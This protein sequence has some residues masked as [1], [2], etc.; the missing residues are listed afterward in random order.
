[1]RRLCVAALVAS[2]ALCGAGSWS[3]GAAAYDGSGVS[4]LRYG[5]AD[6]YETSLLVAEAF[7]ADA[8]G[9]LPSLVLA[10]GERWTDAV[11]AVPVAGSLG[12]PVL[13]TPPDELRGDAVEFLQRAGVTEV[14][15]IGDA[16]GDDDHG[17]SLGVS[18]EVADAVE[19]LGI[20]V[21]RVAGSDPYTTSVAAARHVIPG[22][23]GS[24]GRTAIVASGT[25]STGALVAGPFA[26]RGVHPVLLSPPE[27]LHPDVAAYLADAEIKHVVVMGGTPA[28]SAEVESAIAATGASVTRMAGRT[29][30]G[31]AAETASLIAGAYSDA[32]GR[33]CLA[34]D[35]VGVARAGVPFDAISAAPLL[36][37]QCASLVLADPERI[38]A[39]AAEVL[40][41]A[42]DAGHTFTLQVF[43][44]DAA[45]APRAIDTYLAGEDPM[46]QCRPRG[47]SADT[48]EFPQPHVF[49]PS[50]GT[51][52]VAVLFMDFHDAE[53]E[54]STR[55]EAD[56][57]LQFMEEYIETVSY[58]QLDVEVKA[59]HKWLRAPEP[60][61]HY[62]RTTHFG[63]R[64]GWL[65]SRQAVE[66]ADPVFDFSDTDV[67]LTVFPSLHFGGAGPNGLV[68]AD[69]T[70]MIM[71]AVNTERFTGRLEQRDILRFG[72]GEWLYRAVV[73]WGELAAH[74]LAHG[75]GLPDLFSFDGDTPVL[76]DPPSGME[77]IAARFGVMEFYSYFLESESK[78]LLR[79]DIE[80]PDGGPSGVY[81]VMTAPAMRADEMLAWH[82]WQLD[83]LGESQV[84]CLSGSEASVTLAPIAQ[85]DGQVAMAAIPLNAREVIV[86][87]SRRKLGYDADV[88]LTGPR[89]ETVSFP[90]LLHE[91][92]LVYTVD[93]LTPSGHLPM[94]IAGDS[95]NGQVD[96]YPVLE[97]GESVTVRGYTIT[98]DA[99]N[100]DA[101]AITIAPAG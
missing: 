20:S 55:E 13:L 35:T 25:A 23:M 78:M 89:G 73:D 84:R 88:L 43:G 16:S 3:A 12:S 82:R 38:P 49:A 7:A 9:S 11:V 57:G 46:A 79:R 53:S 41:I 66:L 98:L 71:A 1:M 90:A 21:S 87:E 31:I 63:R 30:Y 10:S 96:G 40:D 80:P 19:E 36:G 37:R 5:G 86:V 67:V 76:P 4:V 44:G 95:G 72:D 74:Q 58:G 29:I 62:M 60:Y 70:T 68:A 42:R 18:V 100:G 54:Y 45:V 59:F 34:P 101:H 51:L 48:A 56:L 26:A 27:R 17:R 75:F 8:G 93:M 24:R 33:A 32:A 2:L 99:D 14:V 91:G 50:T 77:W 65:V 81:G 83:W 69:G 52:R 15:V 92:A 85:P 22:A 47:A 94:R 97:V 39:D 61:D 28:L 6:R 64:L